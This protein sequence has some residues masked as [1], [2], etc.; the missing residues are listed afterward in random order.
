MKKFFDLFFRTNL[1]Q[2]LTQSLVL[3]TIATGSLL[4]SHLSLNSKAYAQTPA[5]NDAEITSYAQAVLAM[6]PLRQKTLEE[7]KK[8]ING[9]EIPTI[10]CNK[11][12]SMNSLPGKAKDI[13][14]NYC[15]QYEKIVSESGLPPERFNQI[16][17]EHQT[18]KNLYRRVYNTL[19]RLQNKPESR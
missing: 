11:P 7:I 19:L 2:M 9:G 6:E 18:N 16:T 13:A 4:S 5:F 1:R 3:T 10:V 15:K 12:D 14:V 8:I 17:V